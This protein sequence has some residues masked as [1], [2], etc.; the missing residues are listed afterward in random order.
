MNQSLNTLNL[1]ND[2][3]LPPL[4]VAT[5][6]L[7]AMA[8]DPNADV[9]QMVR[10]VESD[11]ALATRI[12]GVANSAFYG[13]S[14]KVGNINQ[15]FFVL[16]THTVRNLAMG[17]SVIASLKPTGQATAHAEHLWQHSIA[18]AIAAQTAANRLNSPHA[19]PAFVAGLLHDIGHLVMFSQSPDLSRQALRLSLEDNDGLSPYLSERK[20]FG[21]DHMAVGA[22]LAHQWR[23]PAILQ[24]C[25]GFHHEPFTSDAMT[26]AVLV[27]HVANSISVMAEL[28]SLDPDDAPP[29]DD[30]ALTRLGLDA[31]GMADIVSETRESVAELLSLFVN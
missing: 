18:A 9:P 24:E 28:D 31:G 16:G 15:A 7:C 17:L 29:I 6:R 3:E 2:Y 23:L 27:V 4:P 13:L 5:Q 22:E 20:V 11:A 12:L 14:H 30:R 19:H 1:G 10:V 8:G 21:F 26:D 25:I